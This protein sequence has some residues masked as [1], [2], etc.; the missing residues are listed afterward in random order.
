MG[1]NVIVKSWALIRE[2]PRKL[3]AT[4]SSNP[5][6]GSERVLKRDDT[7]TSYV[8]ISTFDTKTLVRQHHRR[9]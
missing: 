8:L 9:Y 1:N 5:P 7:T 4:L 2:L 3:K 6:G